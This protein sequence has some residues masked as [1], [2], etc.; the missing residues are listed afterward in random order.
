VNLKGEKKLL[1]DTRAQKINAAD[2]GYDK[3]KKVVYVPTFYKN[4]VVAYQL[5]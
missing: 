5:Q 3:K 2:I 4:N 1:L